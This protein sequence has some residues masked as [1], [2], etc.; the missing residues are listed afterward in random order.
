MALIVVTSSWNY[1]RI[2]KKKKK[3]RS[4][5]PHPVMAQQLFHGTVL[6]FVCKEAILRQRTAE[7][8]TEQ[9]LPTYH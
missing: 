5:E 4:P 2:K 9:V 7:K 8:T 1:P 6:S 3:K